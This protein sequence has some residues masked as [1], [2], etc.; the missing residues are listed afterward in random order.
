MRFSK[1]DMMFQ[2]ASRLPSSCSCSF[3]SAPLI[4][5][6]QLSST[7]LI[8]SCR[9]LMLR[10]IYWEISCTCLV[11][12]D[13]LE[14][15]SEL[16]EKDVD[17]SASFLE[18]SEWFSLRI[19]LFNMFLLFCSTDYRSPRGWLIDIYDIFVELRLSIPSSKQI[20]IFLI[21]FSSISPSESSNSFLF[22][23]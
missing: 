18:S 9:R 13:V 14:S 21:S 2:I 1:F 8:L 20:L 17:S 23:S 10:F 3:V 5:P 4:L 22:N 6:A 11:S 19:M 7:A 12:L 15:S 16:G